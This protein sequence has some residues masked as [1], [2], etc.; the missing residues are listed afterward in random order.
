MDSSILTSLTNE[1]HSLNLSSSSNNDDYISKDLV[2]SMDISEANFDQYPQ[3]IEINNDSE[4]SIDLNNDSEQNIVLATQNKNWKLILKLLKSEKEFKEETLEY[5]Y[6]EAFKNLD[7]NI[8]EYYCSKYYSVELLEFKT[9][10]IVF[11]K[12]L[13]SNRELFGPINGSNKEELLKKI[14]FLLDVKVMTIIDSFNIDSKVKS[15]IWSHHLTG[16]IKVAEICKH[17]VTGY[18]KLEVNGCPYLHATENFH[19]QISFTGSCWINLSKYQSQLIED[20]FCDISIDNFPFPYSQLSA[21]ENAIMNLLEYNDL[22]IDFRNNII[23]DFIRHFDTNFISY[24]KQVFIRRLVVQDSVANEWQWYFL[25]K[26]NV[27]LKYGNEN[28]LGER[29]NITSD[30]IEK[31]YLNS[32]FSYKFSTKKYSYNLDVIKMEQENTITGTKRL[33][34]RRPKKH[35]ILSLLYHNEILQP[36]GPNFLVKVQIPTEEFKEVYEQLKESLNFGTGIVSLEKVNNQFIQRAFK[37]R[38]EMM[39]AQFADSGEV[40]IKKLL[41]GT[42]KEYVEK[43]VHENFDWRLNGKDNGKVYGQGVYFTPDPKCALFYA[44]PDCHGR[45]III[46]SSV[47]VCNMIMGNK[48]CEKPISNNNQ[49]DTTVDNLTSPKIY[50]KYNKQEYSPEYVVTI[51]SGPKRL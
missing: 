16:D 12:I 37:L 50:V 35:L 4:Q 3:S 51:K 49:F 33:I 30:T 9:L 38:L 10:K 31:L 46:I 42:K 2:E 34:K 15:S 25:D 22:V 19:W 7:I 11:E 21:Q 1:V 41:H 5:V 6:G 18:C 48:N 17:S 13:V 45:R 8:I 29:S 32:R 40:K 24:V 39:E 47:I 43:I 20:A 28:S 44:K 27:W 36:N 14:A 23:T 26:N